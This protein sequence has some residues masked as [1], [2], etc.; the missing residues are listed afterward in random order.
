MKGYHN[1]PKATRETID[2]EG[3]LHTGDI[4]YVDEEGYFY[5]VDRIL[6]PLA[7]LPPNT[8]QFP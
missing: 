6:L 5:I 3:W 4:A 1:N 2:A 8:N 7:S